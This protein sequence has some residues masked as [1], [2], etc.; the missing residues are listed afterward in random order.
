MEGKFDK[1][2]GVSERKHV[3]RSLA[4]LVVMVG[5]VF[6]TLAYTSSLTLDTVMGLTGMACA[7]AILMPITIFVG[8]VAFQSLHGYKKR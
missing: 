3:G 5:I 2:D 7:G 4:L 1:R 6:G 8:W